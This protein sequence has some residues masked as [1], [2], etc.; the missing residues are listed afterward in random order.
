M[1]EEIIVINPATREEI[2]KVQKDSQ[3]DIEKKIDLADET[4]KSF[5]KL[6]AYERADL[7]FKWADKIDKNKEE[8]AELVTKEGGKPLTEALGEVDYANSY[9]RYYAEEAKRIYGRTVPSSKENNRIVVT[10][11]P[12]GVVAAITPW[13]FPVAMM[14][15]KAAPAVA[16]GNTFIV[17]P[18]SATPLSAMKFIDLALEAGFDKGVIQYVNASGKDAGEIF[19]KSDKIMKLTFTGSTAVGKKLMSDASVTVKNVTMELGGHAPL[20][21]HKDA[22]IDK[23]VEG[24]IASK[25]RNSG[26]TCVCAN[27]LYVHEDVLEEYTEKLTAKVKELKMGNGMEDGVKIGPLIDE[28]GYD[29]VMNQ[30]EDAISKGAKVETGG[31]GNKEAG[32][33]IEPTVLSNVSDDMLCMKE[34]TFGPLAP[35]QSYSNLDEAVAKANGTE[36]GL[37]AYY[38]TENYATGVYLTDVLDFGVLGWNNGAP[39]AANIPFGGLKE[40]GVGREGAIEGLEPYTETKVTSINL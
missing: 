20:I 5:K 31:Q 10:R 21:V 37:A 18:A 8:I 25:F 38:F 1:S 11:H 29:K 39:S 4:F 6:T 2:G 14:A 23:A 15:R 32:Y 24:T 22:D 28:D 26:Q 3:D 19:T 16:A 36:F 9:I 7:L 13:N 27:R 35:I 40:S 12:I 17:K 34:E 30:L 33:F